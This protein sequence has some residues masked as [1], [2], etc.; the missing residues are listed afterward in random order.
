MKRV[1]VVI[2]NWNGEALLKRYLPT[3]VETSSSDIVDVIVADNASTDGSIEYVTTTFPDVHIVRLDKNYGFTGGY[4]RAI[5]QLDYEY[6]VL[7]N[8]DVATTPHWLEPLLS[9]MDSD[10]EIAACTPKIIDDKRHTHFEY[11]GAAG[12]YI[13]WLGY[14][15]CRGRIM[16]T[17]EEDHGQYDDNADC[18]WGSGAALMVRRALYLSY[19]GLDED[20]FA[21]MEEIDLCWRMRNDGKRIVVCG[22]S[23]VYHLGGATLNSTNPRKTYLNFRNNLIMMAKNYNSNMWPIVIFLRLILDGVAGVRFVINGQWAFCASIVKAHWNFFGSIRHTLRKRNALKNKRTSSLPVEVMK[24]S[25]IF[26]YYLKGRK[27][28]NKLTA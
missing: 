28:F 21:H 24:F 20:F 9:L 6:I 18:L 11:A 3:V 5:A 13:D 2:L 4:N 23:S 22:T 25:L 7:L 19:G 15:F 10:S 12:G 17:I 16:D 26:N 27:T 8:S 1:G 14:P